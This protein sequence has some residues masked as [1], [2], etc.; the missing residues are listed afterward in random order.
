MLFRP[1]DAQVAR[2]T[3]P[4][5][6]RTRCTGPTIGGGEVNDGDAALTHELYAC[7]NLNIL[8]AARSKAS[9][10]SASKTRR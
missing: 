8:L 9:V 7:L 2:P 1:I 3:F 4:T 5:T 10:C 6:R